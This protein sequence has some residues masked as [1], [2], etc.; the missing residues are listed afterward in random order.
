MTIR[1]VDRDKRRLCFVFPLVVCLQLIGGCDNGSIQ[2]Y[3]INHM[4]ASYL[5]SLRPRPQGAAGASGSPGLTPTG[6]ARPGMPAT[7]GQGAG[8]VANTP[9]PAAGLAGTAALG[10]NAG[11]FGAAPG[12]VLNPPNTQALGLG[13]GTGA[14]ATGP[15]S[16][17]DTVRNPAIYTYEDFEQLTSVHVN[18]TDDVFVASGY[19]GI[20]PPCAG[21]SFYCCVEGFCPSASSL[22]LICF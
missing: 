15:L 14:G 4:R 8:A 3:D 19:A 16:S 7:A 17:W 20:A 11:R 12:P 1:C 10:G 18:C 5:A 22:R 2:L 13:A 9:P 6:G 21:C